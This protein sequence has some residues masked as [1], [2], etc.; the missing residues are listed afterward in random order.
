MSAEGVLDGVLGSDWCVIVIAN[1]AEIDKSG[2]LQENFLEHCLCNIETL[3]CHAVWRLPL[4]KRRSKETRSVSAG[5]GRVD[6]VL[7]SDWCVIVTTTA[8]NTT[9]KTS[10][11]TQE[12]FFRQLWQK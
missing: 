7:G 2:F 10:L 9:W 12:N 5:G 8:E 1:A 4:R 11:D 3:L 6:V